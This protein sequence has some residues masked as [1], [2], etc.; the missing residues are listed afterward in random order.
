MLFR[1]HVCDED[2]APALELL[3]SGPLAGELLEAVHPLEAAADQLD[4]LAHGR[5]D[6]KVLLDPTTNPT[7]SPS[8][9]RSTP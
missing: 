3:R 6:G 7:S 8:V 4:R 1:S 9:T 2:L 5:L